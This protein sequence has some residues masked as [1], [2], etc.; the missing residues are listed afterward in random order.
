MSTI[1]TP[2]FTVTVVYTLGSLTRCVRHLLIY[3][4]S[5][6]KLFPLSLLNQRLASFKY[7]PDEVKNKP[8]EVS[9]LHLSSSG[10]LRQ[11]GE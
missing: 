2:I 5:D 6:E 10:T 3:Y 4:I 9:A 8:S 7:G 1:S 11:S